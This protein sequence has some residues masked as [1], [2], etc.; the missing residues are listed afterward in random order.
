MLKK[1]AL[2]RNRSIRREY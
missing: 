2:N 1:A